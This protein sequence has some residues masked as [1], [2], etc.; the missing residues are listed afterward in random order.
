[1]FMYYLRAGVFRIYVESFA[2][3]P[4]ASDLALENKFSTF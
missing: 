4:F 3:E 1:M 2:A